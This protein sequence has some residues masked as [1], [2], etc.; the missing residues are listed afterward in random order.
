MKRRK[1]LLLTET[2][3]I[4]DHVDA[5]DQIFAASKSPIFYYNE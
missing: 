5:S 3:Y 4:L 2:F 1:M